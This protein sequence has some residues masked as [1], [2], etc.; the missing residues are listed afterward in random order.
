[1]NQY[2]FPYPR[3]SIN[4]KHPSEP[5]GTFDTNSIFDSKGVTSIRRI[6]VQAPSSLESHSRSNSRAL[7]DQPSASIDTKLNTT[8]HDGKNASSGSVGGVRTAAIGCASISAN[9]NPL[10]SARRMHR[11]DR[12]PWI[13]QRSFNETEN[14]LREEVL[15][16]QDNLVSPTR[17]HSTLSGR[18]FSR[19]E[20]PRFH[21]SIVTSR[22]SAAVGGLKA[23]SAL[24]VSGSRVP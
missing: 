15:S 16:C 14:P 18:G 9:Q 7:V 4:N 11:H 24:T 10:N 2:N 22:C 8:V 3:D 13:L 17:N 19:V 6:P 1:M 23:H 12:S 5:H 20:N 21:R